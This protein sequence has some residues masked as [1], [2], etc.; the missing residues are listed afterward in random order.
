MEQIL[1]KTNY[2]NPTHIQP[3]YNSKSSCYCDSI[4]YAILP[5]P[6]ILNL[7]ILNVD[8]KH[9]DGKHDLQIRKQVQQ[10]L[11]NI[12]D[13]IRSY[14]NTKMNNIDHLRNILSTFPNTQEW[15]INKFQ[16]AGEFLD[17]LFSIFPLE[18]MIY[19]ETTYK[20]TISGEIT[21]YKEVVK[22]KSL[23]ID[24]YPYEI[25]NNKEISITDFNNRN[26]INNIDTNTKHITNE[27]IINTIGIVYR[28]HRRIDSFFI[29]KEIQNP[30]EEIIINKNTFYMTSIV[31]YKN[32][33]YICLFKS[34]NNWILYDNLTDTKFNKI[35]LSLYKNI[36]ITNA[37]LF[38]YNKI[39]KK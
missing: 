8:I 19:Q 2:K 16:D 17:H 39:I 37:T 15:N 14:N 38:F 6:N 20:R 32:N 9:D 13:Y 24:I 23:I 25:L 11:I 5:F 33:H 26:T 36:V 34:N 31:I 12:T 18:K 29:K 10:E 28:L 22:N 30:P 4:I 21:E 27:K 35:N 3:L 1:I 7:Y